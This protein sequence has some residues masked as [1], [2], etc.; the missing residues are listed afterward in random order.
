[1]II[2]ND[3]HKRH[4]LTDTVLALLKKIL[5]K[6]STLKIILV[7]NTKEAN[8][9]ADYFNSHKT[10]R[11]S[12]QITCTILSIDADVTK[13]DIYYLK[14]P[15]ANYISNSIDT[16]R[17]IHQQQPQDGDIIIYLAE[18]DDIIQAMEILKNYISMN[19]IKNLN[20]FQLSH[21]GNERQAV[22]F[23]KTEGK[24]N[25]IFTS[26]LY[27]DAVTQDRIGYGNL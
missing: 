11:K 5:R 2:V 25:V 15:C 23:P 10:N 27:Q 19:H 12:S 21:V 13:Q 4:V 22:F 7:S 26:E 3:V 17:S 9:F 8:F 20:Y 18:D 6:R 16:L 24:R 14:S 1:M